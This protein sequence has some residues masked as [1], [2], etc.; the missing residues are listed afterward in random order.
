MPK[1]VPAKARQMV[2]GQITTEQ[3][4]HDAMSA[5]KG[6]DKHGAYMGSAGS[7]LDSAE[8]KKYP[9]GWATVRTYDLERLRRHRTTTTMETSNALHR[10]LCLFENYEVTTV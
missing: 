4:I 2:G 1:I 8:L 9:D 6:S 10:I 3:L 5:T 7:Q